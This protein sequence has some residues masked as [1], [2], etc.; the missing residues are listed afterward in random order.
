MFYDSLTSLEFHA[1]P[2]T[3]SALA[4]ITKVVTR[5]YP[6]NRSGHR[7]AQFTQSLSTS[8]TKLPRWRTRSKVADVRA[9]GLGRGVTG[10]YT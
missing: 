3:E 6:T 4:G 9:A 5:I 8:E 10:E 1:W 2:C 7:S